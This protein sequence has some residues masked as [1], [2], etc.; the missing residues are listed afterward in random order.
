MSASQNLCVTADPSTSQS[1]MLGSVAV[2]Q[3]GDVALAPNSPTSRRNSFDQ[4][5]ALSNARAVEDPQPQAAT[6]PDKAQ[7]TVDSTSEADHQEVPALYSPF[8][9]DYTNSPDANIFEE[10]ELQDW[11]VTSQVSAIN[12]VNTVLNAFPPPSSPKHVSQLPEVSDAIR[13]SV[14]SPAGEMRAKLWASDGAPGVWDDLIT[15][16]EAIRARGSM[17]W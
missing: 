10:I 6:T 2:T 14:N 3:S 17:I 12:L 15:V 13:S 9:T 8:N 11:P 16:L 1:L 4:V 5:I 7:I